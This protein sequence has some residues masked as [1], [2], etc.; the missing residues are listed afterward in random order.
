V[1]VDLY[2]CFPAAVQVQ[3]RSLGLALDLP[4]TVSGGMTFGGGPLNHAA[5]QA[6]APLVRRLRDAPGERG[7][8]TAVSGMITKPGASLWAATPPDEAFCATDVT[9]RATARTEVRE[10]APD[11]IGPATVAAHT[12]VY[13]GG[14]PARA[15]AVLDAG[16]ARTVARTGD[17]DIVV[18]MTTTDWVGRAVEIVSPGAFRAG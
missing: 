5:L 14:D 15:V 6:T 3:A 4:L 9:T 8:L 7:L 17:P 13:D 11:A 18:D 12:V 2:S 1:I 16:G 10:L